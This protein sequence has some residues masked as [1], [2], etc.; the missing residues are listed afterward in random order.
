MAFS[1]I[2]QISWF[3]LALLNKKFLWFTYF[4]FYFFIIINV[5]LI[6]NKFNLNF[7][8]QI[9]IIKFNKIVII[10]LFFNILSIGG[11]PP[12]LGFFPKILIIIRLKN[13]LLIFL[14]IICT[15]ITLYF[16]LRL[17]Y[18]L[19][20]INFKS[21]NYLNK[22]IKLNLLIKLSFISNFILIFIFFF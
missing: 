9:Y 20:L 21:I 10:F 1:S 5:I 15:L 16:Y 17:I 3:L 22:K 19:L 8:N 18:S 6:F 2:N 4:I 12:F 11:L 7:I 14:I 13:Y